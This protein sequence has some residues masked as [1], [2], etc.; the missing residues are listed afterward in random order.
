MNE[1]DKDNN[2]KV[3]FIIKLLVKYNGIQGIDAESFVNKL[4]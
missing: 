1:V 3:I 4:N 2:E